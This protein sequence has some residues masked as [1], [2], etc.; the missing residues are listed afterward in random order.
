LFCASVLAAPLEA[1]AVDVKASKY[2]EDALVRYEKKDIDGAIIQL[3]NAL[4]V[5]KNNLPAQM[6]LGKALMKNGDVVA[7]EVAFNE[8]LRQGVNRAEVVIPLGEAY[9]AQGKLLPVLQ[10]E[11][12]NPAGLPSTVQIQVILMRAAVNADLGDTRSAMRMINEARSIDPQSAA[13]WLAEV[14]IRIRMLQFKEADIAA[15][16]GLALAP[17]LAEAWYQKG[18]VQHSQGDLRGAI[19][20]YNKALALDADRLDVRVARVGIYVDLGQTKEANSEVTALLDLVPGEPRIAYLQAL[21]AERDNRPV[22]ARTALKE[23]VGLIDPVPSDYLRY[24]PQLLMLNGLAHFGLNEGGKAKQ[25][26]EAFQKI[27]GNSAA[28]KILAQI[29]LSEAN[30]DRAIEVLE[31]YLKA[32]PNDGQ[33]MTMLG[34]AL[35]AKG[36]NAPATA[37]MQK[38]LLTHDD[39]SLHTVLGISLIRG[40]QASSGIAELEMSYKKNPKQTGAAIALI[41]AYLKTGQSAK[42]VLV[43]DQL[44]KLQP[45][46]AEYFNLLGMAQGQSKNLTAARAAFE[47]SMKLVNT[48]SPPKLNLARLDIAAKAY[49]AAASRLTALLK[50]DPR[51]TEAMMEMATVSE[52]TGKLADAQLWLEKASDISGPKEVRWNLALANFHLRNGNATAALEAGKKALSKSPDDLQVMLAVAK[53]NLALGD[54]A[55]AKVLLTQ[56]TKVADYNPVPQVQIAALQLLASNLAGAAYS[57]EKALSGQADYLP[58]QAL[59]AEVALRQGDATKAEKQARDIVAKNPKRAVG[60][61]LLGDVAMVRGQGSLALEHYRRAYQIEPSTDTLLRLAR[62]LGDQNGGKAATQ[63]VEQWTKAHPKD[64][65]TQKALAD[66]YARSGNFAQARVAYERALQIAPDD[67]DVLN[68]LAN[69]LLLL[70]D[71]G[72]VKVAEQALAKNPGNASTIDTLGWAMFKN[73]QIDRALQLL[74]DARLRQ[75]GNPEFGYH[76]ASALAKAGRK[77]E[78]KAELE[79]ALKPGVAFEGSEQAKTLLRSL[80]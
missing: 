7:A 68:N 75:P 24:R 28:T 35:M 12:F 31:T 79:T 8:A 4:Q 45:N 32:Q 41:N 38:A 50:A 63:L 20:S 78:A 49:D 23:V 62:A 73:G 5:D 77:S 61:S 19:A 16:R 71:P 59:M 11:Q 56:A 42:A 22:D 47:Q 53:A 34:S 57:L 60:F 39:P 36:R 14:P 74:R 46:N 30:L 55:A 9:M 25:Y 13:S 54:A 80:N 6:L 40:G 65:L 43:A 26:L 29:Y 72:A 21:L 18:S 27:Q 51:N 33:A 1:F 67:A 10:L 3:K 70:N 37:L 2:Y 64:L 66:S 58:A 52:R 44:V 17:A 48:Y 15:D 69:V 76:L